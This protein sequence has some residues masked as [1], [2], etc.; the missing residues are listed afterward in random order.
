ML[1]PIVALLLVPASA[2]GKLSTAR[3][4]VTPLKVEQ[5]NAILTREAPAFSGATH[6]CSPAWNAVRLYK[7]NCASVV[8]EQKTGCFFRRHGCAELLYGE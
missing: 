8:P 1:V 3:L 7:V 2:Q 5:L 6:A 4:P